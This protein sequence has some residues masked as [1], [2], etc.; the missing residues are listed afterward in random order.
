MSGEWRANSESREFN[1]SR[2]VKTRR[3][4]ER[5]LTPFGMTVKWWEFGGT[6]D[7]CD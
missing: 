1:S 7:D 4:E 2:V 3:I 6:I 5:F